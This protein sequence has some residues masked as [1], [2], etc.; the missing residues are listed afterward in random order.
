MRFAFT[1]SLL[2]FLYS[3]SAG[4]CNLDGI[5]R[6]VA[7]GDI[8]GDFNRFV[9][10]LRHAGLIDQSKNW[11][12]GKTHL[13]QTGD[14][15]DR[16]PDSRQVMDL[17]MKLEE[18]APDQGGAVHFLLGNHESMLLAGDIRYVHPGEA[19]SHGGLKE[20]IRNMR[21]TGRYGKWLLAH[22][23]VMRINDAL[24]LH[25]GISAEYSDYS[26]EQMNDAVRK[27]IL[28]PEEHYEARGSDG[29]LWFRGWAVDRGSAVERS[30]EQALEISGAS[31]AVIG[32]TVRI[33][34][35][36]TRFA[37]RVVMIDTGLS[38]HYGGPVQY[39]EITADGPKTVTVQEGVE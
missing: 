26:P 6:V 29:P 30:L 3:F 10:V 31:F 25:A 15:L 20:M 14:I 7:V 16:G 33:Q 5:G 35:I 18:Q 23:A 2:L 39:L 38:E 37:G 21:L 27:A 24:F 34:G 1:L 36:G 28:F 11:C 8:H 12:G 19:D 22:N 13:V 4:Q 32:H 9:M 17:I